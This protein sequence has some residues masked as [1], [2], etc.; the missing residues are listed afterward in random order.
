MDLKVEYPLFKKK[1]ESKCEF[2]VVFNGNSKLEKKPP[3]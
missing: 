2:K 1:L 3:K